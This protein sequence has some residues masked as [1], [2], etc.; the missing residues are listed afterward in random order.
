VLVQRGLTT[1]QE[2]WNRPEGRGN[3]D[4]TRELGGALVGEMRP[5]SLTILNKYRF[6]C[7]R[8]AEVARLMRKLAAVLFHAAGA[9]ATTGKC[10]RCDLKFEPHAG[11]AAAERP[12]A[13]AW[14]PARPSGTRFIPRRGVRPLLTKV[15][16]VTGFTSRH[17]VA[18]TLFVAI[19]ELEYLYKLRDSAI[20]LAAEQVARRGVVS[21]LY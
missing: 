16:F 13:S 15:D 9:I 7:G 11:T 6:V 12:G 14:R 1:E 17:I 2:G 21:L 3:K 20:M 19:L 5:C 4:G 10:R 18:S 8:R